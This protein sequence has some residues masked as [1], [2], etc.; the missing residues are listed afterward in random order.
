MLKIYMWNIYLLDESNLNPSSLSGH[1][2]VATVPAIVVGQ[3]DTVF[4]VLLQ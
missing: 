1:D 3:Q 2:I 4:H